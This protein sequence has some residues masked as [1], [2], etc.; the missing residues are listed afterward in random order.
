MLGSLGLYPFTYW[1]WA[2]KYVPTMNMKNSEN[3][4]KKNY[5]LFFSYINLVNLSLRFTKIKPCP[6]NL[7]NKSALKM[8]FLCVETK[9]K[10]QTQIF[11]T[12]MQSNTKLNTY[13]PIFSEKSN[14]KLKVQ[15]TKP[16]IFKNSFI[17]HQ[18]QNG[19]SSMGQHFLDLR[20][21]QHESAAWVARSDGGSAATLREFWD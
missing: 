12:R 2:S 21:W 18:Q 11:S 5:F 16:Y 13:F 4:R 9:Y 17:Q 19:I 1:V 7:Q 8:I 10:S 20:P 14:T 15:W 6:K 3:L